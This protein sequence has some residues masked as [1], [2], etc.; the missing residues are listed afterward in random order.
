MTGEFTFSDGSSLAG[1]VF[2]TYK[3]VCSHDLQVTLT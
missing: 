3:G 1:M 2:G